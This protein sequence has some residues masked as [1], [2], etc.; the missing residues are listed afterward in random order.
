MEYSTGG[1]QNQTKKQNKNKTKKARIFHPEGKKKKKEK[2]N[3][4]NKGNKGP[5]PGPAHLPG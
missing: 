1:K 5:L 4:D 2:G 3:K